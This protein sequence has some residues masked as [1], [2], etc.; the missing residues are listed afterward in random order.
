MKISG[1]IQRILDKTYAE[2]ALI[3]PLGN[4][5]V[6]NARGESKLATY[7]GALFDIS[8]NVINGLLPTEYCHKEEFDEDNQAELQSKLE[9][10][11]VNSSQH[12]TSIARH[13]DSY[14]SDVYVK[15]D[16]D[17]FMEVITEIFGDSAQSREFAENYAE[18]KEEFGKKD[19]QYEE[20]LSEHRGRQSQYNAGSE[21]LSAEQS[22]DL[23]R[24][25]G[26]AE[27]ETELRKLDIE[28]GAL[29]Q[30][31]VAD[32]E[33]MVGR[34][35]QENGEKILENITQF[36]ET[37]GCVTSEAAQNM[38]A[39][40]G[41]ALE[42]NYQ[43]SDMT[44][45]LDVVSHSAVRVVIPS[46]HINEFDHMVR[47]DA[48]GYAASSCHTICLPVHEKQK[49]TVGVKDTLGGLQWI[50]AE[51]FTHYAAAVVYEDDN[52]KDK[53]VRFGTEQ[54]HA[55]WQVKKKDGM[56][57]NGGLG[58]RETAF[59]MAAKA[60]AVHLDNLENMLQ[61][62]RDHK[63]LDQW[64][65]Q[66]WGEWKALTAELPKEVKKVDARIL[67][68]TE[69]L[70]EVVK[71]GGK[72]MK[73]VAK[74]MPRAL[75]S[76]Q[77]IQ[78]VNISR[79]SEELLADSIKTAR[80]VLDVSTGSYDRQFIS[81]EAFA[82]VPAMDQAFKPAN[83]DA[84]MQVTDLTAPKGD[85]GFYDGRSGT[86][87]STISNYLLPNRSQCHDIYVGDAREILK[88][89]VA[90]LENH[91][92]SEDKQPESA[93]EGRKFREKLQESRK[94]ERTSNVNFP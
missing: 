7:T 28:R 86:T 22:W 83:Q 2:P 51:E 69:S 50:T 23:Y 38:K 42:G 89:Q 57:D 34:R 84:A 91:E 74:K 67:P 20:E 1:S 13:V 87:L 8:G 26:I 27:S 60:D 62:K 9:E 39:K 65:T 37:H 68:R 35:I 43:S 77:T 36:R 14:L 73:A 88:K 15:E 3:D 21:G 72:I 58:N 49:R 45:T 70:G 25:L 17:N 82:K 47:S 85:D 29:Y 19:K 71:R 32:L 31:N 94:S 33:G 56:P 61:K 92:L 6:P 52:S 78:E 30:E 41:D 48:G 16:K 11:L 90:A 64:E 79:N 76:G 12:I 53:A 93:I 54:Y 18:R 24:K 10:Q 40:L 46:Q 55:P 4:I 80:Y 5:T 81:A 75:L 66:K 59:K 44:A 63:P